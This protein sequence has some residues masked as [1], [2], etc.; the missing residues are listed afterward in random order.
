MISMRALKSRIRG[1]NLPKRF[2]ELL[3]FVFPS[4]GA[5]FDAEDELA[6]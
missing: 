6:S 2:P 5:R 3:S 1:G 4:L